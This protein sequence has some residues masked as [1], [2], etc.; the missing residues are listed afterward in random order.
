MVRPNR[1]TLHFAVSKGTGH[2]KVSVLQKMAPS[3]TFQETVA[4]G[5]DAH[6]CSFLFS[7]R[8]KCHRLETGFQS[9]RVCQY[10]QSQA[11]V[12]IDW[13]LITHLYD[14][15][16]TWT[17]H[18]FAGLVVHCFDS[19][20]AS[21]ASRGLA[22]KVGQT[23][24]DPYRSR[25]GSNRRTPRSNAH[26]ASWCWAIC[27]WSNCS[28]LFCI[29]PTKPNL[30]VHVNIVQRSRHLI[31]HREVQGVT[32]LPFAMVWW[33]H[34]WNT[35]GECFPEFQHVEDAVAQQQVWR[36]WFWECH[37]TAM[38]I[39]FL[40]PLE[41]IRRFQ[42]S[43]SLTSRRPSKLLRDLPATNVQIGQ[44]K[45]TCEYELPAWRR[46]T[47][48]CPI[49]IRYDALGSRSTHVWEANHFSTSFSRMWL[50]PMSQA[51]LLTL[52]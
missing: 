15:R 14:R 19:T 5:S 32:C 12:S 26:V 45:F 7:A 51:K 49:W 31:A 2:G 17:E 47:R 20:V 8:G 23:C 30:L 37:E 36:F 21:T 48:A 24:E 52:Q 41:G 28:S 9:K 40:L 38:W 4:L 10:C 44:G 25:Y 3:I 39:C 33:D 18:C 42:A 6:V 50:C 22:F 35:T 13:C 29:F 43:L 34:A 46:C 1:S 16:L 11:G 27:M